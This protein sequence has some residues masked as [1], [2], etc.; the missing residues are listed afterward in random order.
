VHDRGP[1][2]ADRASQFSDRLSVPDGP[3]GGLPRGHVSNGIVV[4]GELNDLMA[5]RSQ[6]VR[7]V[8]KDLVF[9]ARLLIDVMA[10][11][12][13]HRDISESVSRSNLC[14]D[15]GQSSREIG[16]AGDS[17]CEN[18]YEKT[19]RPLDSFRGR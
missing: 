15:S 18:Y 9:P 11:K 10:L 19:G 8:V 2:S 17:K 12:Y 13:F 5:M 4:A 16:Q 1:F 7:L 6:Q 14:F 3:H